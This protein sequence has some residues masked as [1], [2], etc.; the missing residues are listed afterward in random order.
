MKERDYILK[1]VTTQYTEGETEEILMDTMAL[2]EGNADDY[3]ITYKDEDGDL[4]GCETRLHVSRGNKISINRR[5]VHNSH[6]IIERNVRH[7]SHHHT[8]QFSF[9][10]GVS[11]VDIKSDFDNGKLYFKYAT[12]IEMVPV[13]EIEF[14]FN[15]RKAERK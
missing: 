10:M 11:C 12:D 9:I 14:E 2:V 13:G 5:G 7:L 6:I 1:I 8:P 15:F 4:E 3:F